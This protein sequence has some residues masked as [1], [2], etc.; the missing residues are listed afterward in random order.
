MVQRNRSRFLRTSGSG[1]RRR[2]S[3]GVG[4]RGAVNG[5]AA[6]QTLLFNIGAEAIV[7]DLTL[8]RTRG[9]LI[10]WVDN[11]ASV[12]SDIGVAFGIC[13]VTQN[14]AGIGVTAVPEPFTDLGWDGWLYHTQFH[15]GSD[16]TETDGSEFTAR[17]IEIDGKAMRK[18][19]N[20]DNILGVIQFHD[21]VGTFIGNARLETRML[22]K[23]P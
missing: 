4:P 23:L 7:D 12:G 2:V 14:A 15:I 11:S 13:I 19:H 20:T 1:S 16:G 6:D 9:Q 10:A 5:V 8:V 3:W 17:A 18:L 22:F 21:E